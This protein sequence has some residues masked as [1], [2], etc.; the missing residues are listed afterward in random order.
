MPFPVAFASTLQHLHLVSATD[1]SSCVLV[2]LSQ[3]YLLDTSSLEPFLFAPG[4][5]CR[6]PRDLGQASVTADTG[7]LFTVLSPP[8]GGHAL[9]GH[10]CVSL[11]DIPLQLEAE[12]IVVL[13]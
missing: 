3:S 6:L 10:S 1:A 8:L 12:K 9:S 4:R 7:M 11:M 5:A 13:Q 2:D